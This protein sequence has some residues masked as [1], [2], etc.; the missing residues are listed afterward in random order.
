MKTTVGAV[1][2]TRFMRNAAVGVAD[3]L[4]SAI[5]SF[6]LLVVVVAHDKSDGEYGRA[7][8]HDLQS[9]RKPESARIVEEIDDGDEQRHQTVLGRRPG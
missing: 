5:W 1:P 7:V 8:E 2:S 3:F 9:L 6:A 4:G